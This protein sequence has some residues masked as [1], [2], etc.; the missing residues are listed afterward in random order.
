MCL[1]GKLA[2]ERRNWLRKNESWQDTK[3][4][5]IKV[6]C[7]SKSSFW[8]LTLEIW[9]WTLIFGIYRPTFPTLWKMQTAIKLRWKL[10]NTILKCME[11]ATFRKN[12]RDFRN[13]RLVIHQILK[14]SPGVF[15]ILGIGISKNHISKPLPLL[16]FPMSW[17][18]ET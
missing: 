13:S 14:K 17:S 11:R 18:P 4:T 8:P 1:W 3:E 9:D 15:V 2:N 6:G 16:A 12:I 7:K 10:M 5:Q